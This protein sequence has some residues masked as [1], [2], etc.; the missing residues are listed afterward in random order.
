MNGASLWLDASV[1][2]ARVMETAAATA[3]SLNRWVI[4][5]LP[6]ELMDESVLKPY[7]RGRRPDAAAGA[8][9]FGSAR[10]RAVVPRCRTPA[11]EPD[12]LIQASEAYIG[13]HLLDVIV[14]S[15]GVFKYFRVV[16]GACSS[17]PVIST[18]ALSFQVAPSLNV[19]R[20]FMLHR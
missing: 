13:A 11:S 15:V 8:I 5:H 16:I 20:R 17:L 7:G 1:A 18:F 3:R 19:T 14:T 12:A 6:F 2:P 9:S 4:G 10:E